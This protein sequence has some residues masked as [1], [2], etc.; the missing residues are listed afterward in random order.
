M[1]TEISCTEHSEV[2]VDIPIK[3]RNVSDLI[4]SQIKFVEGEPISGSKGHKNESILP[5]PEGE[6]GP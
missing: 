6:G 3:E 4:V 1:G 2:V 5:S